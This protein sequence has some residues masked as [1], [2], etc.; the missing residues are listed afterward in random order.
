MTD[1]DSWASSTP[2][3]KRSVLRVVAVVLCWLL[4][5]GLAAAAATAVGVYK[6]CQG[7]SGPKVPL[8]FEIPQGATG[9][10]VVEMLKDQGV[11]R[12]GLVP[13]YIVSKRDLSFEAGK[14]DLLTNMSLESAL[15]TLSRGPDPIE[16]ASITIPE[17]WRLTQIAAEA[18]KQLQ[19]PSEGFLVEAQ[20]GQHSLLPYLPGGKPTTEGFLF[21][22][23]YE[24]ARGV[25]AQEVVQR[26]LDQFGTEAKGLSWGRAKKLGLTPYEV[27]IVASMIE[28]EA[29]NDSERP[30][31]AS[32]IYNRLDSGMPL[33][34]DATTAYVD[35]NPAN[36]L[37][38]S[39]LGIDSPYDTRIHKG[40]PPTPIAS[41]GRPS[42]KAALEP[43]KTGYIY[44]VLCGKTHRF[45]SSYQAFV[46][47][48]NSCP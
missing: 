11:L 9:S 7:A 14:Y 3:R 29:A 40:L 31:I 16:T 1:K 48:K 19:I 46:N 34:I 44:F 42:L 33:Q 28:R 2:P 35:P 30:K 22:K 32:V 47:W 10:R 38:Q 18:E 36:G 13:R 8:S 43:A 20:N 37:T 26:M 24:F 5:F 21:P 12:C 15:A 41:P 25:S 23:T 17:G 39:D 4:V 6:W 27:V 45:T